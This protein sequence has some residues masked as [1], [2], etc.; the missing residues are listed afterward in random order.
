M[1][2]LTPGDVAAIA[3]EVVPNLLAEQTD[4]VASLSVGHPLALVYLLRRLQRED[5]DARDAILDGAVPYAD[6]IDADYDAHWRRVSHDGPLVRALALLARVRGP[7]DTEWAA[8]WM[9][10]D[11]AHAFARAFGPYFDRDGS[12][13]WTF[14]HNSFRLFLQARTEQPPLGGG[15]ETHVQTLHRELARLYSDAE[16]STHPD[17]LYHLVEAGDDAEAVSLATTD[18]F[19]AQARALRPL[20]AV[21][22]DVRLA[23]LAA[24]RADDPLALFRLL[25]V[26]ADLDQ[27]ANVL[28]DG[29]VAARLLDLGDAAAAAE[30]IRDGDRLRVSDPEALALAVRLADADLVREGVRV[31]ELAAPYD[32][33]AGTPLPSFGAT[34][35]WDTIRAWADAAPRFHRPQD[36]VALVRQVRYEPDPHPHRDDVRDAETATADVQAEL[37]TRLASAAAA[38]G[39]WADWRAYLRAFLSDDHD[40]SG[41]LLDSADATHEVNPEASRRLVNMVV[42][43]CDPTPIGDDL[44]K[45]AGRLTLAELALDHDP[46]AADAWTGALL[47]LRVRTRGAGLDRGPSRA[48]VRLRL[49]RIRYALGE[50][51]PPQTLITV[52]TEA[53]GWGEYQE[54]NERAAA[55]RL[56]LVI[57]TVGALWG[58]ARRGDRLSP[59]AFLREANWTLRAF[60]EL[61]AR[62]SVFYEVG[63]SR[64]EVLAWAAH[65]A[66]AH[67]PDVADALV[68][69]LVQRWNDDWGTPAEARAV[70]AALAEAGTDAPARRAL[71]HGGA[72]SESDVWAR[73]EAERELAD[74]YLTLGD[75]EAARRHLSATVDAA[76]GTLDKHDHQLAVW[77]RWMALANAADPDGA[78]ERV[79][80]MIRRVVA[81]KDQSRNTRDAARELVLAVSRWSPRRSV[82]VLQGLL[83][84][85]VLHHEEG[86]LALLRGALDGPIPPAD[87][88]LHA[89]RHLGVPLDGPGESGT[90]E[91]LLEAVACVHSPPDATLA[92]SYLADGARAESLPSDRAAWLRAIA[93]GL[94]GLGL[95]PSSVGIENGDLA[96]D[97][98]DDNRLVLSDGRRLTLEEARA[99]VTTAADLDHLVALHDAE[100]S[101]F[102]RW[103]ELA[104]WAAG[105]AGPDE[106]EKLAATIETVLDDRAVAV[107]L[108]TLS[109]RARF[110]GRAVLADRLVQRALNLSDPMGWDPYADGGSRLAAFEALRDAAPEAG[111]KSAVE[112][113]ADDLGRGR[114]GLSPHRL[115]HHAERLVPLLF[116]SVPTLDVW[117]LVEHYLDGLF[118]STPHPPVPEIEDRLDAL[119][120][121]PDDDTPAR[122]VADAVAAYLDIPSPHVAARATAAAAATLVARP[123]DPAWTAAL[124][125][126]VGRSE[127]AT[128]RVLTVLL[129]VAEETSEAVAPFANLL[130]EL[131]THPHLF[132]RSRAAQVRALVDQRPLAVALS[133]RPVSAI[134]DLELPATPFDRDAPAVVFAPGRNLR[135][136]DHGVRVLAKSSGVDEEAALVRATALA[137]QFAS[138]RSWLSGG[139]PPTPERLSDVLHSAGLQIAFRK[140]HIASAERAVAYVA[141]ELYDD[142]RLPPR[143]A[144]FFA[145]WMT[146]DDPGLVLRSPRSRP[147]WIGDMGGVGGDQDRYTVPEG[148]LDATQESLASL[149]PAAPDGRTILAEHTRFAYLGTDE[150]MEEVRSSAVCSGPKGEDTDP[151][152]PW[153]P[154]ERV[155]ALRV[156][157]YPTYR[158]ADAVILHAPSRRA[159][160]PGMGWIAM[161]PALATDLGWSHDP[162]G[163]FRWRDAD[164]DIAVETM[165]W[166][167]GLVERYDSRTRDVVGLGWVVLASPFALRALLDRRASLTR[168]GTA[169]RRLGFPGFGDL[170]S[171]KAPLAMTP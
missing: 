13:R 122:A 6:D 40:P 160:T 99:A 162:T 79:R 52:D 56:A 23:T 49:Y 139:L 25:L 164:G 36:A 18:T 135:P 20:D 96:R 141:G 128:S 123:G 90:V 77:V 145:R 95:Q 136:L 1:A 163:F 38:R 2:S 75:A 10:P 114:R 4:R 119:G 59:S 46:D 109:G 168:W 65:A 91:A 70:G 22:A 117:H 5:V 152:E 131:D 24:G 33:L 62:Y 8:G 29:P 165:W 130:G 138:E 144:A 74:A 171:A 21:Q 118:A 82:P 161:S 48:A 78:N 140:P 157:D 72:G 98:P 110:A 104:E 151:E 156:A 17:A 51:R 121:T 93:S 94:T 68:D 143:R 129:A 132:L 84:R 81:A 80:L 44:R 113:L 158:D 60:D 9:G 63:T 134:Y 124:S 57:S 107:V 147:L 69:R 11:V 12:R 67:G 34:D 41:L 54:A 127:E 86:F 88:V 73:V 66:A 153:T 125:D 133:D 27:R 92:A 15:T 83:E 97:E 3:R 14:F 76:R 19:L 26:A 106:I 43:R 37:L 85:G 58:R 53:T 7:I 102:Y 148:W 167:D 50:S 108:A 32:T 71:D 30:T 103:R 149:R 45:A 39:A 115:V 137:E 142:R 155:E 101:R 35:A 105:L 112:R 100:A 42:R 170:R 159:E 55:R 169:T 146:G 116:G 64:T 126:A 47:P 120:H 87:A 166:T 61:P 111:R 16:G 154:F 28:D 89:V 31:F 150:R